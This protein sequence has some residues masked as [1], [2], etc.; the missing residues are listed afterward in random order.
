MCVSAIAANL[1]KNC[2]ITPGL[3]VE[4]IWV[5]NEDTFAPTFLAGKMTAFVAVASAKVYKIEGA[6]E[7]VTYSAEPVD[8]TYLTSHTVNAR[9][10]SYAATTLEQVNSMSKGGRFFVIARMNDGLYRIFGYGSIGAT[11]SNVGLE[12]KPTEGSDVA[13][14]SLVFASPT[15][16]GECSLPP[17]FDPGAD[18]KAWLTA[19]VAA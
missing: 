7:S 18:V 10:M 13:G 2:A 9:A 14:I 19:N 1:A 16:L 8:G 6:N 17:V 12:C 15:N 5:G 11:A 3:R 4:E